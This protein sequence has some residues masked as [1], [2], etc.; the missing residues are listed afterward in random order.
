MMNS[1][2]CSDVRPKDSALQPNSPDQIERNHN[3]KLFE[4]FEFAERQREKED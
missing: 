4:N 1:S 3:E 2:E